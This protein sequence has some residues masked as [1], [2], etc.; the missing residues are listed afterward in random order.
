MS[1]HSTT[2]NLPLLLFLLLNFLFLL[3]HNNRVSAAKN[4]QP[5]LA[6]A[7]DEVIAGH[8]GQQAAQKTE[9]K[10]DDSG[11]SA[12]AHSKKTDPNIVRI[13]VLV[14]NISR[15]G[16]TFQK[17]TYD[18]SDAMRAIKASFGIFQN[19]EDMVKV[20]ISTKFTFFAF[21]NVFESREKNFVYFLGI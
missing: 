17:P 19:F 16:H 4:K 12:P 21:P 1:S 14:E 20:K 13:G 10:P 8:L 7:N 6:G 2:K 3:H 11:N 9:N 15:D 18:T 5:A